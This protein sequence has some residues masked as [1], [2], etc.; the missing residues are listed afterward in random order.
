MAQL[1]NFLTLTYY[2]LYNF[3]CSTKKVKVCHENSKTVRLLFVC[4]FYFTV[5][6]SLVKRVLV[7]INI[8]VP[9]YSFT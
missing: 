9:F 8:K 6:R 1:S 3:S 7:N 5:V 4:T 2:T